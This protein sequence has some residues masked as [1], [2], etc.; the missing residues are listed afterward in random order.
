MK[1]VLLIIL[2]FVFISH[3]ANTGA[4]AQTS[5]SNETTFT[6]EEV[7]VTAEKRQVNLQALPS[8]VVAIDGNS[9]VEQ[10][11]ITTSQMLEN[12]PNLTYR[13]AGGGPV[14]GASLSDN[15]DGN[16]TIRGVQSTQQTGGLPGPSATATYIDDVYQGIGGD[17]DINRVEV[18]SG[19]QGT[20]Y[21]R[22]ATGGVVAF[23]TNDPKLNKMEKELSVEYG[24]ESRINTQAVLNVPVGD[25]FSLRLAARYLHQ[26]QGYFNFKGGENETK[27]GRIKALYQPTE[28]F[29]ILLSL[30]TRWTQ[31]NSGGN[32][33]IL[34]TP[35]TINYTGIINPVFTSAPQK[36]NQGSLKIDYSFGGSD[37]TWISAVHDFDG[38]GN[39]AVRTPPSGSLQLPSYKFLKDRTY[40]EELRWASNTEGPLSWLIGANYF[41]YIYN[42]DNNVF[43]LTAPGDVPT[44]PG[45]TF[46]NVW[47]YSQYER[48][49]VKNYGVFTEETYKLRDDIRIT[50]GLRY[51]NNKIDHAIT[52]PFNINLDS[53]FNSYNINGQPNMIFPTS[54]A[55][56]NFKNIT[57]KARLEYDL[58]PENM[59]YLMTATG[60]LPGDIQLSPIV[61]VGPSI[62]VSFQDLP[63]DQER[64]TSYEVGT[65]NRFFDKRLQLNGALFYYD[66]AGYQEAV[67]IGQGPIPDYVIFALPVKM[68]GAEMDS[69]W[70]ITQS[71]KASLTAGWLDAYVSNYTSKVVNNA[72]LSTKD[73]MYFKRL[74]G[75][76][77]LTAT[78]GYDHTFLFNDGSVLAP[79]IEF[80]YTGGYYLNQLSVAQVTQLPF[81]PRPYDYQSGNVITN[82]TVTWTSSDTKYSMTGYIRNLFNKEYKAGLD[83]PSIG[84]PPGSSQSTIVTPGDPR[85]WGVMLRAK[86]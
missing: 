44:L 8:S 84:G 83:I 65:K 54:S 71:D 38:T 47:M 48:E 22:S 81:D 28:K 6:L 57:Y 62:S 58:R 20:L 80:R 32:T 70:L 55:V 85:T 43:Q 12:V 9:L 72:V 56:K 14:A 40:T 49:K 23:H 50:G 79:H 53:M 64:L 15:P 75:I 63:F 19:P 2:A 66:Y 11:K 86:F 68:M 26:D 42:V 39:S 27:E 3:T 10:G 13:T 77:K 7:T 30:S 76:P 61:H 59:L 67:N 33:A 24:T 74:P 17:L 46:T 45:E 16:I 51:D 82:M 73:F 18:L 25:S 36:A 5:S 41:Y 52:F 31:S 60:F 37:L 78:L 4:R 35:N 21:G 29:N 34:V 1:K 69:E